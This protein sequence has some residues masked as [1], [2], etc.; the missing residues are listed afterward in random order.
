MRL[1]FLIG[2]PGAGKTWWGGRVAT[3]LGIDFIDLDG[4]LAHQYRDTISGMFERFGEEG[5]RQKEQIML[6]L[7]TANLSRSTIIAC[8]GGTPCFHDN[9]RLMKECG[10]VVYLKSSIERLEYNLN[11]LKD[12]PLF[13]EAL[14]DMRGI[15]H[16]LLDERRNVYE[17]ADVTIDLD[18]K[19]VSIFEEIIRTCIERQ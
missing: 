7:V 17:Q 16:I 6:Q 18:N 19:E 3:E 11:D 9:M 8:G 15:L 12:R 5:F 14:R 2:M 1:V 10:V 4:Q 13:G